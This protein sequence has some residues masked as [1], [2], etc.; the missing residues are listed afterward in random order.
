MCLPERNEVAGDWRKL[1]N[2]ELCPVFFT[3][4]YSGGQIKKNEIGS[5]V[6]R[7]LCTGFW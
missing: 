1:H 3:K 2:E 6:E 5:M 4:Y 7:R